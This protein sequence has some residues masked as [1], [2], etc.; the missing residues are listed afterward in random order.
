MSEKTVEQI[1]QEIKRIIN[2]HKFNADQLQG[3]RL[4]EQSKTSQVQFE[5]LLSWITENENDNEL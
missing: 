4:Y 2:T 1:V 3:T 5:S